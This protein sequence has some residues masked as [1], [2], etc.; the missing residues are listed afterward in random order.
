MKR[1]FTM[2]EKNKPGQEIVSDEE[3]IAALKKTDGNVKRASELLPVSYSTVY[4]RAN[5]RPVVGIFANIRESSRSIEI[6]EVMDALEQTRGNITDAS[7]MLNVSP[8]TLRSCMGRYAE[9]DQT[10]AEQRLAIYDM[11]RSKMIKCIE[12]EEPWAI[13][14]YFR[15]FLPISMQIFERESGMGMDVDVAEQ[16]FDTSRLSKDELV[17]FIRLVEKG[18]GREEGSGNS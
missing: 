8:A 15:F 16:K 4:Y 13:T 9:A 11:A 2:S 7:K 18:Y 1:I 12:R 3:I 17:E 10:M 6:G 14:F 5:T